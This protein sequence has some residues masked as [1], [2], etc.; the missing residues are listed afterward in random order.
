VD[1]RSLPGQTAEDLIAEVRRVVGDDIEIEVTRDLPPVETSPD[2]LLFHGI[3]EGL[4]RRDPRG[5]AI[6]CLVPGATDAKSWARLGCRTY[7]FMPVRFPEDGPKF[8]DLFHGH[9]ERIPVA[10]LK[11]G[12]DLLYEVVRDFVSR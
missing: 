9:D 5:T 4:R 10:G 6:P 11:W 3:V 1:G 8:G 12:T 7:G 2:S